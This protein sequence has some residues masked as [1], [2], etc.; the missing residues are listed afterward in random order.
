MADEPLRLEIDRQAALPGDVIAVRVHVAE[1]FERVEALEI[2]L[3]LVSSMLSRGRDRVHAVSRARDVMVMRPVEGEVAPGTYE[4]TL[5]VP[6]DAL[7]TH[8]RIVEWRPFARLRRDRGRDP[9]VLE[10]LFVYAVPGR[11][12]ERANKLPLSLGLFVGRIEGVDQRDYRAGDTV[13]GTAVVEANRPAEVRSIQVYLGLSRS[14]RPRGRKELDPEPGRE[15][16]ELGVRRLTGYA[17][18]RDWGTK[19]AVVS[20]L[21][22]E[23]L[24]LTPG[25]EVRR[26]FSLTFP[27]DAVPTMWAPDTRISWEVNVVTEPAKI[28]AKPRPGIPIPLCVHNLPP[29]EGRWLDDPWEQARLRWWDGA[30]W[31]AQ[32]NP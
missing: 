4:G 17:D 18:E 11:A 16:L 13:T 30:R 23:H 27:D 3:R 2:G 24:S 9:V 6:T 8:Y 7:P 25:S 31:T 14:D 22:A 20:E 5:Q 12:W 28:V 1:S 32:T 10:R 29:G 21:V 19:D 15:G 26:P